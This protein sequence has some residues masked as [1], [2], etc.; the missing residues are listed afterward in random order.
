M[1]A[2]HKQGNDIYDLLINLVLNL[3]P[4]QAERVYSE[5]MARYTRGARTKL[6]NEFGEIDKNGK[7][8]LL[9]SQY[10]SMRVKFGDTYIRKA[11]TEL[12]EYIKYLETHL[13]DSPEYKKKLKDYNSKTHNVILTEG[14]VYHKCKQYILKEKPKLNINPYIIDDLPTAKAYVQS[15]P[16]NLWETA[17]DVKMLFLKFP[18]LLDEVQ[19]GLDNE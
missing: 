7:V 1:P 4:N 16:K 3:S 11:F 19:D 14:W 9:E 17:M 13:E 2:K 15:I 8:R 12:T 6:Y 10:K 5:L 18:Q